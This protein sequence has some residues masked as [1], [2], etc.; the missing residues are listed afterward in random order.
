M[1][2]FSNLSS[3]VKSTYG[4]CDDSA[5]YHTNLIGYRAETFAKNVLA[6]VLSPST[7]IS[8]H[9]IFPLFSSALSIE[10]EQKWSTALIEGNATVSTLF[11]RSLS[12]KSH[13]ATS[14]RACPDCINDDLDKYGMAY[15]RSLHQIKWLNVC[16]VHQKKLLCLDEHHCESRTFRRPGEVLPHEKCGICEEFQLIKEES[17]KPQLFQEVRGLSSRLQFTPS[18]AQ[19]KLASLLERAF[20]REAV[21]LRPA[22]RNAAL[23]NLVRYSKGDW[24]GLQSS[25]TKWFGPEIFAMAAPLWRGK[26]KLLS[27]CFKSGAVDDVLL[28]I[29]VSLYISENHPHLNT[30][31]K[32]PNRLP[33]YTSLKNELEFHSASQN[34]SIQAV[35]LLL[36]RNSHQAIKNFGR[37]TIFNLVKSLS[38][39]SY[40]EL[41]IL[42]TTTAQRG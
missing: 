1:G 40:N 41:K 31:Q 27:R 39:Q 4:C 23:S 14:P 10:A 5:F 25:F 12:L 19:H 29:L 9:S 35:D 32:T 7:L 2:K 34:I 24:E 16:P 26:Q 3:V 38:R 6:D 33:Y 36:Q 20:N 21:E 18:D 30:P 15:W 13:V 22:F 11:T 8:Q 17:L 42:S 37:F 28:S